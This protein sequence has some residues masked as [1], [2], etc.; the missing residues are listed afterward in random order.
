MPYYNRYAEQ[1]LEMI[2]NFRSIYLGYAPVWSDH[3]RFDFEME[4]Y[5]DIDFLV[6]HSSYQ[7]DGYIKAGCSP[8]QLI[9]MPDPRVQ[10]LKKLGNSRNPDKKFDLLWTPHWTQRWYGYPEGYSTW[11]WATPAILEFALKFPK[12]RILLRPHPNIF[13]T[14]DEE[15]IR[16]LLPD[17]PFGKALEA[18]HKLL[19]L[20]N[21][22]LSS[23]TDLVQD[24]L[25]SRLLVSD[26]SSSA[27][28]GPF[29]DIPVLITANAGGPP[30]S[31]LAKNVLREVQKAQNLTELNTWLYH[32]ELQ[33]S[34][35][36]EFQDENLFWGKNRSNKSNTRVTFSKILQEINVKVG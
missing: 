32:H 30:V 19:E 6:C 29:A 13:I 14:I 5:K 22:T 25:S 35:S 8:D 28:F 2:K 18:W 11:S 36:Q 31:D 4:I 34:Q 7:R 12:S 3:K 15:V 9:D 20:P 1:A 24:I 33:T 10:A 17:S 27:V 23:D 26:Y 21:V 16:G